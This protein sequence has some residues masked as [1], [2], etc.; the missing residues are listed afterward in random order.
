MAEVKAAE[1]KVA[2]AKDTKKKAA[3]GEAGEEVV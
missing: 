1:T 3:K 2:P